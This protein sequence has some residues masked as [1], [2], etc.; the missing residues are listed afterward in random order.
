VCYLRRMDDREYCQRKRGKAP[1]MGGPFLPIAVSARDLRIWPGDGLI[2]QHE[3]AA[4]YTAGERA[5][6]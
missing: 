3:Q 4:F 6:E 1:I 5:D 2:I